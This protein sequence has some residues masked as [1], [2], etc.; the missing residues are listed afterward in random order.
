MNEDLTPATAKLAYFSRQLKLKNHIANTWVR[1]GRVW[2]QGGTG[3]RGKI[4]RT[5]VELLEQVVPPCLDPK[6]TW[7]EATTQDKE[8]TPMKY[9][10]MVRSRAPVQP[11][12]SL[13]PTT[14]KTPS[15]GKPRGQ[16]SKTVKTGA[17]QPLIS[18]HLSQGGAG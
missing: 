17:N 6:F 14:P 3:A 11:S 1:D 13:A 9:I 4:V 2:V 12:S 5:T 18:A 16:L 7:K 8:M 10:D 15:N